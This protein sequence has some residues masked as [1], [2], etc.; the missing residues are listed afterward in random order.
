MPSNKSTDTEIVVIGA[1]A[2]GLGAARALAD[3]GR[4]VTVLEA[5]DRIG[6]RAATSDLWDDLPVAMGASWIY[7]I[8]GNPLTELAQS[9]GAKWSLTSY[10]KVL[11]RDPDGT[12]VDYDAAAD[13]ALGLVERARDAV[14]DEDE[15]MSLQ[16]AVEALPEWRA[17][18]PGRRSLLRLAI[19]TR[20]EHEYSGDWSRLSAW[21]FDDGE[22][23]GGGEAVM[24]YGFAPLLA[25]LARDIDIRLNEQVL[26]I[27]PTDD[28]VEVAT[29]NG[30]HRA[31]QAVVTL[32]IGVLKSG[33]VRFLAPLKK[34][35]VKSIARLETGLL[36]K[37]WLRFERAFWPPEMYWLNF[38]APGEDPS[39]WPE[40]TSFLR[41]TGIPLLVGFN[42]AA[43][44][45]AVEALDDRATVDGAMVA[46]RAMF[47]AQA[48]DPVA[49]QISR[50]RQDPF[51]RGA[52]SF[53]PVGSKTKTRAKFGGSDW[54]GRLLFA[55]EAASVDHP[56][57]MHGALSTGRYAASDILGRNR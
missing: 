27:A 53:L 57:T 24:A 49:F 40:F 2:A 11:A 20:I 44:A 4:A 29:A 14:D 9:V 36:N 30:V 34:A 21:Y 23:H 32:P 10:D 25:E 48:P 45:E 43:P 7:G 33:D 5:K 56:G 8:D 50:W 41:P 31:A 47:G 19:H 42:A 13:D 51:A 39:A 37:C 26:S 18:T 55:G 1:G 3:A 28:G 54:D 6:G 15:D 17:L 22:D 46:L 35:R 52:Y 12:A 16:Q 38:V